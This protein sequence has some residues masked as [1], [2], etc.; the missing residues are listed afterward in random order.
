MKLK[1]V[2]CSV[3]ALACV[4]AFFGCSK[5]KET[6]A[7]YSLTVDLSDPENVV[8]ELDGST[9]TFVVDGNG[10]TLSNEEWLLNSKFSKDYIAK[11][12]VGEYSFDYTSGNKKGKIALTVTDG[13][14]PNYVF[15]YDVQ[16]TVPF[17]TTPLLPKLIKS[18]D[19][20]QADYVVEYTLSE[21]YDGEKDEVPFTE[22]YD[23]YGAVLFGGVTYEWK[24][25]IEKDGKIYDYTKKFKTQSYEE[26]LDYNKDALFYNLATAKF[27]KRKDDAYSIDTSGNVGMR[28]YQIP[29]EMILSAISGGYGKLTLEFDL[30]KSDQ[31]SYTVA[32]QDIW[33]ANGDKNGGWKGWAY[34]CINNPFGVQTNGGY[35]SITIP[36][37]ESKFSN[38][39]A[40][41]ISFNVGVEVVGTVK[42]SW[43]M[44]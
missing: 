44:D 2:V 20:F 3:L 17:G 7:N 25:S 37:D 13:L 19:S 16:T 35:L 38:G 9:A 8:K 24:A 6:V 1:N 12:G 15:A 32:D 26:W 14:A 29:N 36:L 40:F 39:E 18:Q 42:L 28:H 5:T 30:T 31:S 41:Q 23:G 33:F 34:S 43:G 21:E 4:S 22:E 27:E 11:L 10:H